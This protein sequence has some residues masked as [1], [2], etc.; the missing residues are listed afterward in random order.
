MRHYRITGSWTRFT[1]ALPKQLS[2]QISFQ[3]LYHNT[4]SI[5]KSSFKCPCLGPW[6]LQPLSATPALC[7]VSRCFQL[8]S[9]AALIHRRSRAVQNTGSQSVFIE[10]KASDLTLWISFCFPAIDVCRLDQPK[11]LCISKRHL[12]HRSCIDRKTNLVRSGSSL[13]FASIKALC[14][15]VDG[16][17]YPSSTPFKSSH[18]YSVFPECKPVHKYTQQE[19]SELRLSDRHALATPGTGYLPGVQYTFCSI[20]RKALENWGRNTYTSHIF[21]LNFIE[22]Y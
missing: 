18:V 2:F 1:K 4:G 10:A 17:L 12:V 5:Y 22:T 15:S 6:C 7:E 20:I 11:C 8:N 13:D 16:I 14:Y 19:P 3:S 9:G 21:F